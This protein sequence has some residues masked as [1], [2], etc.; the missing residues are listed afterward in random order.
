MAASVASFTGRFGEATGP[1]VRLT[2]GP[3]FAEVLPFVGLNCVRWDVG[4]EPIFYAEPPGT[5]SPSPTRSGHPILFPFPNRI[6]G[7]KFVFEGREYALPLND[8]TKAHAIHGF[9]PRNPW[10]VVETGSDAESAFVT[11]E[12]QLIR[13]LPA[14]RPYWPA[15]FTLA[16]TY[17]LSETALRVDAVVSNPDTTALPFGLGYHPYFSLGPPGRAVD[18]IVLQI[19]TNRVWQSEGQ[20]PT[21]RIVTAP[22]HLNFTKPRPLGRTQLDDVFTEL[23]DL[24]PGSGLRDVAVLSPPAGGPRLL[25]RADKAFRELV[26]FT[27]PHRT[28]IAVEP[29]TCPTDAANLEVRGIPAGWRVLPPGGRFAAAV[30]YRLEPKC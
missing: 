27:P 7:G 23:T 13:D 14:A 30:E 22:E 4:P 11:G 17:R 9:T 19:G 8:S 16:V 21:G 15:D 29:Y 26:L 20:L 10:R 6:R 24:R 25:V 12:F 5:P 28:A 2:A 1:A 18:G 3:A